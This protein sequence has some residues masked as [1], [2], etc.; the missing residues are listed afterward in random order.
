MSSSLIRADKDQHDKLSRRHQLGGDAFASL[1]LRESRGHRQI[2]G[3]EGEI[4][5]L[6]PERFKDRAFFENLLSAPTASSSSTMRIASPGVTMAARTTSPLRISKR[7]AR[8]PIL[9]LPHGHSARAW[10]TSFASSA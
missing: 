5:Y 1:D 2:A 4:L 10:P 9:A 6:T 3:G 8:P 7:L